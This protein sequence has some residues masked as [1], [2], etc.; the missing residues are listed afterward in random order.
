[1]VFS[2]QVSH[3]WSNNIGIVDIVSI[4]ICLYFVFVKVFW[5]CAISANEWQCWLEQK[6]SDNLGAST[7]LPFTPPTITNKNSRTLLLPLP[8]LTNLN[9]V[10][11]G[12]KFLDLAKM[13]NL[14]TSWAKRGKTRAARAAA[15]RNQN[16][17]ICSKI[18]ENINPANKV[19]YLF[20]NHQK[21]R[22]THGPSIFTKK[23]IATGKTSQAITPFHF[24]D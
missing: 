13:D 18:L 23:N 3:C 20:C 6:S 7:L 17:L 24:F 16:S 8:S 10:C 19:V 2:F 1:M 21:R 9:Q 4:C 12:G 11:F 5:W 14:G 22:K 15:L